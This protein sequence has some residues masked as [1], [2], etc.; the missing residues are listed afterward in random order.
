MGNAY[1]TD[2]TQKHHTLWVLKPHSEA[3]PLTEVLQVRETARGTQCH[4]SIM[5]RERPRSRHKEKGRSARV[6]LTAGIT[7][8]L[9]TQEHER[10][11]PH[12][13]KRRTD[14][15]TSVKALTP[16]HASARELTP[17]HA[18]SRQFRQL[19]PVHASYTSSR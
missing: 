3:P 1:L 5:G 8:L 10:P 4:T 14:Q 11:R 9:Q 2:M 12:E 19:T 6:P 13:K 15:I 17:F 18:M 7:P 16:V